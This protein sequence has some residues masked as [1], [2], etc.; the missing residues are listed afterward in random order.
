MKCYQQNLK[1]DA[2][3]SC[4]YV[5]KNRGNNTSVNRGVFNMN[6]LNLNRGVKVYN[7]GNKFEMFLTSLREYKNLSECEILWIRTF[8][9]IL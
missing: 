1:G 9:Y 7:M 3:H 4:L 8:T 5:N 6:L 2:T